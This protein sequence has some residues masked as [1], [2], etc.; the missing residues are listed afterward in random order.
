MKSIFKI[1]ELGVERS[2]IFFAI[3][4]GDVDS[5][6][7]AR[8]QGVAVDVFQSNMAHKNYRSESPTPIMTKRLRYLFN[9]TTTSCPRVLW[10]LRVITGGGNVLVDPFDHEIPGTAAK[11]ER[12]DQT[13]SLPMD[14]NHCSAGD[15]S[16]VWKLIPVV[17]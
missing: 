7:L 3:L 2:R 4:R 8:R 13:L 17:M 5:Q 16:G 14:A 12:R 10:Y 11:R 9:T 6:G 15:K 1:L